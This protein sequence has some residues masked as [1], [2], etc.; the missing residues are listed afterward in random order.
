MARSDDRARLVRAVVDAAMAA[1]VADLAPDDAATL[2]APFELVAS[3]RGAAAAV[4]PTSGRHR[5][6][7]RAAWVIAA[8]GLLVAIGVAL[9]ELV[10]E[11]VP[12]N[13]DLLS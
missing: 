10:T 6:A 9:V 5:N 2:A 8:L 4:N 11:L 7:V 1:V 12:P 3:M 13:W